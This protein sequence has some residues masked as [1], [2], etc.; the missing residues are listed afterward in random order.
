MRKFLIV[1]FLITIFSLPAFTQTKLLTINE[2]LSDLQKL[3]KSLKQVHPAL[4]RFTS[5][6]KIDSA[7]YSIREQ[8]VS[9]KS[10]EEFLS[11]INSLFLLIKDAHT[12]AKLPS[13]NLPPEKL[14]PFDFK[15]LND[16]LIVY[17][18]CSKNKEL[19]P[20]TSITKINE[21][22]TKNIIDSL[23]RLVITDGFIETTKE[24]NVEEWFKYSYKVQSNNTMTYKRGHKEKTTTIEALYEKEIDSI[25]L[26]RAENQLNLKPTPPLKPPFMEFYSR[27]NYGIIKLK[28]FDRMNFPKY[29]EYLD[30]CIHELNVKDVKNLIID[31]R[32]NIGGPRDY[33]IYLLSKFFDQ[34][35]Y[36]CESLITTK[37]TFDEKNPFDSSKVFVPIDN[38]L[39]K[40]TEN[41]RGLGLISPADEVFKGNIFLLVNGQSNS[42]AAQVASLIYHYKRGIIIGE[43]PG[44]L[45]GGGTGEYHYYLTLTNSKIKVQIP[46]YRIV[47]KV[48][49]SKFV[50]HGVQP[51][52]TIKT[53]INKLLN[54][55]DNIMDYTI[56]LIETK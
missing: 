7:I 40:V 38:S 36:Y 11:L 29:K 39:Y 31:L 6:T 51:N 47:L 20:G 28:W 42:S 21:R 52:H 46:R 37:F 41:A 12:W 48:D 14:I 32:W 23:E 26:S 2:Q 33:S 19:Q 27:S 3:E 55:T 16:K 24:R 10:K 25:R 53:D 17:N 43:E 1:S 45:Y 9:P 49:Q 18:N 34:P 56:N 13:D 4:Y 5:P 22:S 54:G 8:I 30:S 35:F 15:I 44:G 50:G